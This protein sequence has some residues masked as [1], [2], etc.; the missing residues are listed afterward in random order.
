MTREAAIK[1]LKSA[2]SINFTPRTLDILLLVSNSVGNVTVDT[3]AELLMETNPID[4]PR[5]LWVAKEALKRLCRS[6]L[7]RMVEQPKPALY[8]ANAK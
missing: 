2:P 8:A 4:R 6:K 3:V 5:A 1:A 7:I